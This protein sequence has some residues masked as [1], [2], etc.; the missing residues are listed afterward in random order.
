MAILCLYIDDLFITGSNE[1]YIGE[2]MS[3]L[4]KEF[5]MTYLGH[6][7]YFLGIEF[8]KNKKGLLLHQKRYALE[9]LKKRKEIEQQNVAITP[10]EPRL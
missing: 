1:E 2:L 7:V 5:E 4:M 3:D 9:I 6:I 10:T 8:H